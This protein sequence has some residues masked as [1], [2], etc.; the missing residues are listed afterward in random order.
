MN[1]GWQARSLTHTKQTQDLAVSLSPDYQCSAASKCILLTCSLCPQWPLV[2][3]RHCGCPFPGGLST[4]SL[5]YPWKQVFD[6]DDMIILHFPPMVGS[7]LYSCGWVYTRVR[8]TTSDLNLQ[9]LSIFFWTGPHCGA[10]AG[11]KLRTLHAE[12]QEPASLFPGEWYCK[13]VPSV[14]LFMCIL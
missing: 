4:W 6:F 3:H 13:H 2:R 7:L 10:R 9:L 5:T 12:F 1:T 11:L 14:W 8:R